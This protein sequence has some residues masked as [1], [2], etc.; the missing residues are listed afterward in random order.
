MDFARRALDAHDRIDRF[1]AG[2]ELRGHIRFGASEDF[3]LSG[4]HDVL[5]DFAEWDSLSVLSVIAMV[6]SDYSVNLT[7]ANLRGIA[8]AQALR[9]LVAGKCGK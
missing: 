3:V 7:A 9:D 8:T 6:G 1:F 2:S 4:L 5:A